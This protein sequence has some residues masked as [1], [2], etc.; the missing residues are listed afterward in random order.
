M[1]RPQ[2]V[3][4]WA[5]ADDEAALRA[6]YRAEADGPVRMRLQGLWLL[7]RGRSVDEVAAT[8][9]VHRRTVDRWVAWYRAGGVAGVLGHRQG[10]VGPP[11][12]LTAE[13]REEIAVAVASG[14][15]ATATEIGAWI[16]ET[17]GVAYRPGGLYDLLGRL[18][19]HPKVP[20]PLHEK[21]DLAAQAAWK[22]GASPRR[23]RPP[24]SRAIG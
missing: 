2:F 8:V 4:A 12:R 23:S 13:Q 5:D 18:R 10:G 24:A 7:R 1:A 11:S 3:M 9:G 21:A 16:D 17:Y 6:R 20:R 22:G 14:R 19:C 15:F